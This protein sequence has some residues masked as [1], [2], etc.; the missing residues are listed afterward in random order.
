MDEKKEMFSAE[1]E[2]EDVVEDAV[3]SADRE[4]LERLVKVHGGRVVNGD[5]AR[6]DDEDAAARRGLAVERLDLVDRLAA[7]AL[8]LLQHGLRAHV[9]RVSHRQ[10]ALR[11][12]WFVGGKKKS[13]KE[14]KGGC[15][16][17]REKSKSKHR[18]R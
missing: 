16:K 12:L 8:Q 17:R 15:R 10:H 2:T 5:L 13:V 14:K 6:D 7:K 4:E 11:L 18:A 3:A 9:L 1:V